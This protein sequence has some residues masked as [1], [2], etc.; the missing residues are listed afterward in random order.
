MP[1]QKCRS[2]R[3]CSDGAGCL[4]SWWACHRAFPRAPGTHPLTAEY[5]WH[6]RSAF[7]AW[8][9]R[10]D[11][12]VWPNAARFRS[13]ADD[14]LLAPPYPM[15]LRIAPGR[16]VAASNDRE[17]HW[18]RVPP[19][20]YF[21]RRWQSW[22]IPCAPRCGIRVRPRGRR[23]LRHGLSFALIGGTPDTMRMGECANIAP[24]P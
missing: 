17:V 22:G 11:R 23:G 12:R 24:R 13:P 7:P 6:K 10:C 15:P 16:S 9:G 5:W 4:R 19:R 14:N 20:R 18:L 8:N 3:G 1:E 21:R 2:S